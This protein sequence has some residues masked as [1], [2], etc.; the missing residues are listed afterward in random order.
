[1]EEAKGAT[2]V[3][4]DPL[5]SLWIGDCLN[6]DH[7]ATAMGKAVADAMILDAPYSAKTHAG[8][9]IGAITA[10]RALGFTESGGENRTKERAYNARRAVKGWGRVRD[11][12]YDSWSPETVSIF[13]QVWAQHVNGWWVTVTDDV[14]APAWRAAFE[15]VDLY[16][17]APLPL[18]ETGSRVRMAGD[19]PSGWTCWIVVARPRTRAFASWGT[20]P[21]A[22]V[23]PGERR[24]NS[25]GGSERV[26]G[27]KPLLAMQCIVDDYSRRGGLVVDPCSGGGTTGRA[28]KALGRR[29]IGMEQDPGRAQIAAKAIASVN[30]GQGDLFD[31]TGT[32]GT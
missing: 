14:L 10:E 2:L 16:A 26:V 23:V 18:V 8:H 6:A 20:L 29:F 15:A 4:S 30:I 22:Y 19:G 9:K 12:D 17:F 3:H 7:V 25:H 24:M 21:G 28:A 13:V 31:R 27:G 1:M 5:A 11:I 32:E